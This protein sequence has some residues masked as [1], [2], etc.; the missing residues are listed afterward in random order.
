MGK[1]RLV[2][3]QKL[4]DSMPNKIFEV[5]KAKGESKKYEIKTCLYIL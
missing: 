3:F 1:I 5:I 4:V 2:Q